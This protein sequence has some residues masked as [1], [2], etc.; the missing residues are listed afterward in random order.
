MKAPTA[1]RRR[2]LVKRRA[3]P[4]QRQL[5]PIGA[6][7]TQGPPGGKAGSALLRLSSLHSRTVMD[8]VAQRKEHVR[9]DIDNHHYHFN[10]HHY[11][12]PNSNTND[13]DAGAGTVRLHTGHW[14]PV[15]GGPRV[16]GWP[17]GS[18]AGS[19]DG[20]AEREARGV[21]APGRFRFVRQHPIH[22]GT[23]LGE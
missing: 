4:Q 17:A 20:C 14:N 5:A 2:Q 23:L 12:A 16:L 3:N 22:W 1:A 21:V 15:R 9:T 6:P 18:R 7:A 13:N 19:S 10:H 8:P 11:R